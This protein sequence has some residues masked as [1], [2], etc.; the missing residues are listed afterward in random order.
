MQIVQRLHQKEEERWMGVFHASAVA[1]GNS[2]VLRLG[3]SGNGKSTSLA[4]L[5]AHGFDCLADD[6]VPI[7]AQ[8]KMVHAFPAAISV[9]KNSLQTLLPYYPELER[10]PGFHYTTGNKY[11][12]YLPPRLLASSRKASCKALIFI[13]YTTEE[14]C[15]MTRVQNIDVLERIVADSWLS[16]L[17]S[18]AEC[19][20]NWFERQPCYELDYHDNDKMIAALQTLFKDDV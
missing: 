15:K 19:F 5:Q 4:L 18:N 2:C 20:L 16:P 3:D 6:F 1:K 10:R 17:A 9:K 12:K 14:G 8:D 13:R 7:D 11:V